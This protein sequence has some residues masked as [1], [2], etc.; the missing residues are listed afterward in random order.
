MIVNIIEILAPVYAFFMSD[1]GRNATSE[2]GKTHLNDE[3]IVRFHPDPAG[4]RGRTSEPQTNV[5]I[6]R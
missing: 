2:T 4:T 6:N 3:M 5:L 1:R